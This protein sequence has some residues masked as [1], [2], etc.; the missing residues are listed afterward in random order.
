MKWLAYILFILMVVGD[1]NNV[2]DCGGPGYR[3]DPALSALDGNLTDSSA[4]YLPAACYIDTSWIKTGIYTIYLKWCSAN[5]R[6]FGA[7]ILYNYYQGSERYRFLWLRSFHR[8]VLITIQ[9]GEKIMINTKFLSGH[10]DFFTK[11]YLHES[12]NKYLSNEIRTLQNIEE[13][14]NEFPTADSVILPHN[15]V[16]IVLDTTYYLSFSQWNK[17]IGY[18]YSCNFW[19]MI[20]F[21]REAGL[22]GA[23][24]ILEGQNR[25][26]YHY[27]VQWSP[28]NKFALC[29]KYLIK[30]SAAKDEE[31]Y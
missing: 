7:P 1:K 19:N 13:A 23:E 22:D 29:C 9:K 17:F 27:V 12:F 14:R 6:C 15:N 4:F 2:V 20:P 21:K 24:W 11:V 18:V 16:K 10:P 28:L 26:N 31:I 30:L 3:K 8:P 5:Y 25:N